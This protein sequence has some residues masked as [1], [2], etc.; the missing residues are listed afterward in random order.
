[1]NGDLS[2]YIHVPFCQKKCPYCHFY[3][4][5]FKPSYLDGYVQA[6]KKEW[7]R[8]KRLKK[9]L[10]IVSIMWGGGT[11]SLLPPAMLEEILS[12]FG[13]LDN[14]E[15]SLE[16]NP[17]TISKENARLWK[18][19][20]FN[21]IS[22]GAQSFTDSML[23][24]IGRTHSA[25]KTISAIH[26]IHD[27]GFDNISADLMYELP[28]QTLEEWSYTLNTALTLPLTHISLYNLTIEP[29]TVF[30][31]RGDTLK[32]RLPA[33]EIGAEMF[34]IALEKLASH[35]FLHYEIGS[36]AK[37]TYMSSHN[38]GYWISRPFIGLG[39][40]AFSFMYSRRY[41]NRANFHQYVKL[42]TQGLSVIDFS[43]KLPKKDLLK[44][45]IAVGIRMIEGIT[46][47]LDWPLEIQDSILKLKNLNLIEEVSN[48]IRMTSFGLFFH[49]KIAE[50]IMC[51]N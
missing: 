13:P 15:I 18:Q 36:W 29:N 31:A 48:K 19:I 50:I 46:I 35:D 6:I 27:A 51:G 34:K 1:M 33:M 49:D 37:K 28:D 14:I 26:T 20:G 43:E 40:S 44:E 3:V 38:I 21:R 32:K 22:I 11:P 8:I 10:R 42:A 9:N 45:S 7:Q 4:V 39:P 5:P 41:R 23:Q 17:E 30:F 12:L 47:N 25:D 24:T 16:A 2:I